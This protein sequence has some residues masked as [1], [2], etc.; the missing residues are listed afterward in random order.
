MRE[1]KYFVIGM[2]VVLYLFLCLVFGLPKANATEKTFAFNFNR[3]FYDYTDGLKLY[4]GD[5]PDAINTL[6]KDFS[7]GSTSMEIGTDGSIT[8]VSIPNDSGLHGK[9]EFTFDVTTSG[10]YVVWGYAQALSGTEDSFYVSMD[11][12]AEATW[13]VAISTGWVW[14]KVN[15]RDVADPLIFNLST[16]THKITIRDR[17]DGTKLDKIIITNN[18]SGTAPNVTGFTF[19]AEDGVDT[20]ASEIEI[21]SE[22]PFIVNEKFD[23]D[24]SSNYTVD[25]NWSWISDTQNMKIEDNTD[26]M[27]TINAP[28]GTKNDIIFY[29]WPET[30][31]GDNSHVYSYIKQ[32]SGTYYELR[33]SVNSADSNFRKVYNEQW[34]GVNGLKSFSPYTQCFDTL[35]ENESISCDGFWVH[36][37]FNEYGYNARVKDDDVRG[38]DETLLDINTVEIIFHNQSGWI[39]NIMIGGQMQLR[40]NADI[41]TT[42]KKYYAVSAY[43]GNGESEK[44]FPTAYGGSGGRVPDAPGSL[45]ILK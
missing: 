12:G 2:L 36:I 33:L 27:L 40:F 42:V 34:G 25:G 13:D 19:E 35:G 43:N 11:D 44:S 24:T 26:F 41:D 30:S 21:H 1:V 37:G 29:F 8:Y 17:E 32:D 9:V 38:D 20:T 14:D 22:A 4:S 15:S 31:E 10:Q 39:D 5:S 45:I 28:V 18:L 23:T 16:G 6:V 7:K 3:F